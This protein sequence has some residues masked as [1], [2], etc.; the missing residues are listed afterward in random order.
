MEPEGSLPHSQVPA[1]C[2]YPDSGRSSPYPTSHFLKIHLNIILSFTPVSSRWTIS[3]SLIHQN[4]V[5]ASPLPLR[6]TCP[7]HPFLFAF[8]THT[9]FC[10]QYRTSSFSL[11][12]FLHSPVTSSLSLSNNKIFIF[13]SSFL[14]IVAHYSTRN[15]QEIQFFSQFCTAWRQRDKTRRNITPALFL[16][17]GRKLTYANSLQ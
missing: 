3:L 11:C 5:R 1:T 14:C 13:K 6:A 7:A 17:T 9:I 4:L 8:I 12:C 2:Q 10:E 16:A 15:I